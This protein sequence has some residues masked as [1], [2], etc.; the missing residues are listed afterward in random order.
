MR[1]IIG[2]K[3]RLGEALGQKFVKHLNNGEILV[4]IRASNG[5]RGV[6]SVNHPPEFLLP[7]R[8]Q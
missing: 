6:K 3:Y 4:L 8:D 7:L 2:Y 1:N 5:S